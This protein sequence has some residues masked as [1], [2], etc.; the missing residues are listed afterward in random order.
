M[1]YKKGKDPKNIDRDQQKNPEMWSKKDSLSGIFLDELTWAFDKFDKL[2]ELKRAELYGNQEYLEQFRAFFSKEYPNLLDTIDKKELPIYIQALENRWFTVGG[3]KKNTSKLHN[4]FKSKDT[5]EHVIRQSLSSL[6]E[7]CKDGGDA[8]ADDTFKKFADFAGFD[9]DNLAISHDGKIKNVDSLYSLWKDF[10][11][12]EHI[13]LEDTSA[14]EIEQILSPEYNPT[15]RIMVTVALTKIRKELK[16]TLRADFDEQFPLPLDIFSPCADLLNFKMK[17]SR[18]LDDHA[19]DIDESLAKKLDSVIVTN[20]DIHKELLKSWRKFDDTKWFSE[21][22]QSFR[23]IFNKLVTR[24]LFEEVEKHQDIIDHYLLAMG[25]A[26]KKFPPYVNEILNIYPFND[27]QLTFIDASYHDDLEAIDNQILSLQEGYEDMDD[28]EKNSTRKKIKDLKQQR[29]QRKRQAYIAF[30]RTKEPSLADIF[31]Q[32]VA[33]K[34]DFSTL[35]TDQQQL[36]VDTLVKNKLE[37]TIKNKV[38]ELLS[39]DDEWFSQFIRDLFDLK[40]MDITV[41]TQY[42]PVPIS[43]IKKEFL[44]TAQKDLPVFS[45]LDRDAKNLPLNFV[46]QIT[47]SNAAF[48]EDSPIFDSIYTRFVSKSWPLK[49][50]DSYKV[51]IKKDGKIVEW[52]LS[53]YCPIDEYNTEEYDGKQLYLYSEPI[54][55]PNQQR[56]LVTREWTPDGNPVM[57]R[58]R[59]QQECDVETINKT[60]NLN[61]EALGAMIFGYV[62][63]QQGM[64]QTISPEQEQLL[65]DKLGKLNVYKEKEEWTTEEEAKPITESNQEKSETSEK[66]QFMN[67]WEKLKGYNF[68]DEKYKDN[69]GFTKGSRLFLPFASSEV[70][71]EDIGNARVQMEIVDVDHTKWT[72]KV[73]MHGGELR[74]WKA[75][76]AVKELPINTASLESIKKSFGSKIYKLPD[77]K[78][79]SFDST[80][81]MLTAWS[82]ATDLDKYFSSLDFS[83]STIKY[84]LWNYAKEEVTHF[85]IYEPRV[86]GEALDAETSKLILYKIKRNANGT[87]TVSGDSTAGN[88]AKN[89]PARD[90]DYASFILFV[91]EKWLQPKCKKQLEQINSVVEKDDE[92]PAKKRG[93]SIN[94]MVSFF[95]TGA[96]KI[97]DSIKKYDEE[98]NEDLTDALTNQGKLYSSIGKMFG[99]S[100]KISTAFDSIGSEYYSER[101]N[102]IWKKV[103]KRE[104][105][106]EDY[107]YSR[108]Y[109]EVVK[110]MLEWTV[111]ITPHYKIA[112]ILLA[113]LKKGKWPHAKFIPIADG[114]RVGKVLGK[115]HQTR[116]LDIREKKIRNLEQNAH[117]HPIQRADNIKDELVELE[118]RYL[119]HVMD[120]RQ[121]WIQDWDKTKWHFQE[122]YS[123]KFCDELEWAYTSFYKQSTVEEW[124]AKAESAN[125]EFARVEFFRLLPDRPQ[126][127]LPYLKVM[128]MKAINDAQWQ[129]FEASVLTGVLSG[130]FINMTYSTTQSYIQKICRTRWFVPWIFARDVKQQ[131]KIQRILD[132]F[133]DGKFTTDTW[134]NPDLL[135][136]RENKWPGAF[137][138][139]MVNHKKPGTGRMEDTSRVRDLSKFL[140]LTGKNV[141]GKT[142]LDIH[143]DP[144]TSLSDKLLLEE[145]IDKTNEKNED[146]DPDV[147]K[148]T[149]SLTG[150][151]LTKSQ[152]VVDQMIQF[153]SNWFK[154][155]TGD[156]KEDMKKFSNKMQESIPKWKISSQQQVEFFLGKFFNRFGEKFSWTKKTE[157][158]KRLKYCKLNAWKPEIDDILYYS[159]VW[160]I[161]NVLAPNNSSPPDELSWALW[162]WQNFFKENLDAIVQPSTLAHSF[163]GPSYKDEYDLAQPKFEPRDKCVNLLDRDLKQA[164]MFTVLPEQRKLVNQDYTRLKSNQNYL[165]IPLYEVADRLYKNCGITNRFKSWVTISQTTNAFKPSTPPKATWA[166]ISNT[167]TLNKLRRNLEG[168]PIDDPNTDE[169]LYQNDIDDDFYDNRAA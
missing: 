27:K 6:Q 146:L 34:F 118:M 157:L 108:F 15:E 55:A 92:V 93:F 3:I 43:F 4:E 48:F 165:N 26:F 84:T 36:L 58:D 1:A 31:N 29:E 38:P 2:P 20:G 169:L 28:K 151:I 69:S 122:K 106:Y 67:E 166:K 144:E 115:D 130:V 127:A 100:D 113:H 111:T 52:Y 85:G 81:A 18:F 132:L 32:L 155:A 49:I 5:E 57:I 107:D 152:S 75:E 134:Y 153:D 167:E 68:S 63:G 150:S 11:K 158:L 73:K 114:M 86:I 104:K 45:D 88:Y 7:F 12:K 98:R 13:T 110:P 47:E 168:K 72:F 137:V 136:L 62:L 35:P 21:W 94:N 161:V 71:P 117:L 78:N 16:G 23:R 119:V 9:D 87:I 105:F 30:L 70:P 133:S 145:Y 65:A 141:N 164:H 148:N 83:W 128:G 139:N 64:A 129:A 82:V 66:K 74:L 143:S 46:T 39:V 112:A 140:D 159:I 17:R 97:K 10:L 142:L 162:A 99:F 37:D 116:Y 56:T 125:F 102:R 76:W 42:G 163:G 19:G 138:Q 61:G 14:T 109:S 25:T 90:M 123:K 103:E 41:P 154:W 149:S 44:A 121:M 156:A 60:I 124:F 101:D 135:S 91:K 95:T 89:F 33:S 131:T 147:Q 160:E 54:T 120:G 51:K 79:T 24:Q 80:V 40:K 8:I 77:P 50:N 126:Q 53:A 22:E 59:E 96:N